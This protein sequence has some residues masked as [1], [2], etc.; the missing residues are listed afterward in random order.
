MRQVFAAMAMAAGLA[1]F[2]AA[3]PVLAAGKTSMT[4]LVIQVSD[5]D[6]AKWQLA[7]NNANNVRAA[8]GK[9][10]KIEIVAYGPGLN[11]L[12]ADSKVAAGLDGA[13]DQNVELAACGNT[14]KHMKLSKA[15][16]VD[17]ATVVPAGVTEIMKRQ[18]EGWA[19]LRP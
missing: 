14:M 3:P 11:M 18:S 10:V 4:H 15:D 1:A 12:K 2:T 13:L 19:Y 5:N 7:L 9:D 8:L 17:G 16:L 6:P